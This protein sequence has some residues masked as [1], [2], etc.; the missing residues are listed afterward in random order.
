MDTLGCTCFMRTHKAAAGTIFHP[1]HH[2]P[3]CAIYTAPP[4]QPEVARCPRCGV[5]GRK[6]EHPFS[7]VVK[8]G[9][10]MVCDDC[11]A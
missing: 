5:R 10:V 6:G 3:T 9:P 2:D 1:W 8:R 11:A 7:T 4:A